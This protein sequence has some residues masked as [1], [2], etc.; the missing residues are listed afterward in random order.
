MDYPQAKNGERYVK[1]KATIHTWTNVEDIIEF[2]TFTNSFII[3]NDYQVGAKIVD[4]K[5]IN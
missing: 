3:P 4:W 2:D 1:V 5:Y